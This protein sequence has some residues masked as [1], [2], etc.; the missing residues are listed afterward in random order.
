MVRWLF[1]LVPVMISVSD[2]ALPVYACQPSIDHFLKRLKQ[3][4]GAKKRVIKRL[5]TELGEQSVLERLRT[6]DTFSLQQLG[7][8]EQQAQRLIAAVDL[9]Q[10]VTHAYSLRRQDKIEG[11]EEAAEILRPLIGFS[12]VEHFVLLSLNI[13]H[14]VLGVDTIS[15]GSMRECLVD[16]RVLL[17][18]LIGY[19]ATACMVAHNHPS[20]S[21]QP[22]PE[23]IML[24]QS[25]MQVTKLVDIQL[26]DHL[27]VTQDSFTSIRETT[28]SIW[29]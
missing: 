4:T 10:R 15:I 19:G 7:F 25:L 2:S 3:I 29:V 5:V 21:G 28:S 13:K 11:P 8:T 27:V 9:G 14:Q 6:I 26:L 20:G 1:P 23:D 17:R 24:T 22:S 18:T 12:T 16:A